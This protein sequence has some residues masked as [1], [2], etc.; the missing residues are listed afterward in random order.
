MLL[1]AL[2]YAM[3]PEISQ[4]H[5]LLNDN[6]DYMSTRE[7]DYVERILSVEIYG[8]KLALLISFIDI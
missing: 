5:R 8:L 7:M 2:P 6:T 4:Y 3:T 1:H